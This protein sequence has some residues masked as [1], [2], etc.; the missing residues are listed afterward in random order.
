[1]ST[2]TVVGYETATAASVELTDSDIE[3]WILVESAEETIPRLMAGGCASDSALLLD[4]SGRLSRRVAGF[5][6]LE[7]GEASQYAFSSGEDSEKF[8]ELLARGLTAGLNLNEEEHIALLAATRTYYSNAEAGGVISI[9][10]MLPEKSR[11]LE[12]LK[13]KLDELTLIP[14][15]FGPGKAPPAKVEVG[16]GEMG[17]RYARRALAYVL[18]AKY[19]SEH[20]GAVVIVSAFDEMLP[21][22]Q[23]RSMKYPSEMAASLLWTLK[24]TGM[25][26]LAQSKRALPPDI[27]GIFQTRFVEGDGRV[28]LKRSGADWKEVY[29]VNDCGGSRPAGGGL[30]GDGDSEDGAAEKTVLSTV[31]TYSNVTYAGLVSFLKGRM[32]ETRIQQAMDRLMRGGRLEMKTGQGG[33]HFIVITDS[34]RSLLSLL[35]DG[36]E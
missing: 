22:M 9:S 19:V 25:R 14:P 30:I 32:E 10:S 36:S 24:G 28:R 26:L 6:R 2:R 29:L 20:P 7:A 27:E 17:G 21:E 13:A 3:G 31:A 33:S 8:S 12:L 5:D 15:T 1:M 34:G 23:T 18:V 35:E 4:F 11:Q 16:L